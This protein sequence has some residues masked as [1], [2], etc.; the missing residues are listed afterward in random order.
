MIENHFFDY[1]ESFFGLDEA[2]IGNFP[3]QT[4]FDQFDKEAIRFMAVNEAYIGNDP[5]NR[6]AAAFAFL[7]IPYYVKNQRSKRS[8]TLTETLDPCL[9][10]FELDEST[11]Y[12]YKIDSYGQSPYEGR[13]ICRGKYP[14][15]EFLQFNT[16]QEAEG[17]IDLALTQWKNTANLEFYISA[18][19]NKKGYFAMNGKYFAIKDQL[20]NQTLT[21]AHGGNK[22]DN[23]NKNK[24]A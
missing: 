16:N 11:G 7:L 18:W 23:G 14:G 17:F 21:V 3:M 9:E 24:N 1:L 22:E 6:E 15:A 5:C 10:G 20:N 12:C 13:M 19:K 2:S 8:A 4:L